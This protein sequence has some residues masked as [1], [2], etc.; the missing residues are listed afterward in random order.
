M[1]VICRIVYADILKAAHLIVLFSLL[2][3]SVLRLLPL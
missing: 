2:P 3:V 1:M